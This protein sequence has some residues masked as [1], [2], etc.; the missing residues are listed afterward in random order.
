M[1]WIFQVFTNFQRAVYMYVYGGATY[2]FERELL[3]RF[4][5][6]L[7]YS[8]IKTFKETFFFFHFARFHALAKQFLL[9]LR[10][11]TI[12]NV[13]SLLSQLSSHALIQT[14]LLNRAR[15]LMYADFVIFHLKF[16]TARYLCVFVDDTVVYTCSE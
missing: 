3:S 11:R 15:T 8:R 14:Y 12:Y 9:F 16:R 4:P 10:Y 7:A 13:F 2:F 6:I 1:I 5:S